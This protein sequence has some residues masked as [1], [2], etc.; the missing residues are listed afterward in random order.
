MVDERDDASSSEREGVRRGAEEQDEVLPKKDNVTEGSRGLQQW[1][2][3]AV[4]EGPMSGTGASG[5]AERAAK[6]TR[7]Q[8]DAGAKDVGS[9][10]AGSQDAGS[11]DA[12]S[13]DAGSKKR[14]GAE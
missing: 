3:D 4:P 12:G 7:G 10:D 1:G 13:K 8:L 2:D 11:K 6:I 14:S 5:T 9:K